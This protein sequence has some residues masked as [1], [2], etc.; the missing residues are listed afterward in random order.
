[1]IES[2]ITQN[3]NAKIAD[4]YTFNQSKTKTID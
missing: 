2:N 1:L 4:Q 3:T